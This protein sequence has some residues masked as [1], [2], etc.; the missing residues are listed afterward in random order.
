MQVAEPK[1]MHPT[2]GKITGSINEAAAA[3]GLSRSSIYAQIR[4][5]RLET[6]K[7]GGRTLVKWDSLRAMLEAA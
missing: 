4:Q 7:F 1:N 5:G 2:A 3:T 6:V